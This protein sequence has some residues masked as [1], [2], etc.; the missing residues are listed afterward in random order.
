M[1]F[2]L[3]GILFLAYEIDKFFRYERYVELSKE[4]E[5]ALSAQKENR[6]AIWKRPMKRFLA[7]ELFYF[8]WSFVGLFSD[9][10]LYFIWIL[11]PP[12]L[13]M[14]MG[15]DYR[16]A[17]KAKRGEKWYLFITCFLFGAIPLGWIIYNAWVNSVPF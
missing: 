7:L 2:Y 3:I 13:G 1:I 16:E 17:I 11:I 8:G 6:V 12:I 10:R 5:H 15:E 14:L 4:T 9:L